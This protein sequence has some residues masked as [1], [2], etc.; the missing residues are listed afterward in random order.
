MIRYDYLDLHNTFVC[1]CTC[2]C[3][4]GGS[5]IGEKVFVFPFRQCDHRSPFDLNNNNNTFF[6]LVTASDEGTL[7]LNSNLY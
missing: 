2:V 7:Q 5:S 3:F 6:S 1:V 4:V